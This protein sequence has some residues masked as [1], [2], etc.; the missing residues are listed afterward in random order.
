MGDG[1]FFRA[2]KQRSN[3]RVVLAEAWACQGQGWECMPETGERSILSI[4]TS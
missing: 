4:P 2:A 1:N 3:E